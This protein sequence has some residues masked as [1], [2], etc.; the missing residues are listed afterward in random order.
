MEAGNISG[1]SRG[2]FG[3]VPGPPL[4]RMIRRTERKNSR[5]S[6]KKVGGQ[7]REKKRGGGSSLV[8]SLAKVRN[9]F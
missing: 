7:G 1:S 5:E 4:A 9:G 8:A 3:P 2:E 6:Q